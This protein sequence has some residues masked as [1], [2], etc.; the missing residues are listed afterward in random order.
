MIGLQM[1]SI[2]QRIDPPIVISFEFA[3]TQLM[4]LRK[5]A[6]SELRPSKS[7]IALYHSP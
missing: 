6:D 7:H 4:D 3:T 2:S 1:Q 5:S